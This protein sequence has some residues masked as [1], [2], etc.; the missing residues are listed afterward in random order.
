MPTLREDD[1]RPD[2]NRPSNEEIVIVEDKPGVNQNQDNDDD[3]EDD[4]RL[5]GSEDGGADDGN[6]AERSA[7]RERRRL[8]KLERKDRREQAIKRDKLELDFLR[9]RNDDLER[10]LGTVEH[11]THQADLSQID[12]QIAQAKNEA[13]MAERVIAKAVAAGNGDD[14][15]Q[16]MRYRDQAMQKANQ[17]AFAKQQAMVQRQQANQPKNEGLDDMAMHFAKE[18][19]T[20][21]SWYDPK[22]QDEDSAIVLAIDGA[23]HREGFRPDTE[24]YWDELRDRAARRIPERFKATGG[25]KDNQRQQTT[26]PR[27]QRGGPAIGSG[28]EHAPTSTRTEVYVSPERKQAL[29]DAG[30]WDDPV[31]RMKYVKRYAEYDRNNRA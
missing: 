1:E 6:D 9:K 20:E 27:Q 14:V 16:A 18:F 7:I 19:I 21:N 12:T 17:L 22:G 31:L 11:R 25:A 28:R 2:D 3:N 29:I 10:R 23:L 24:E 13:E 15:A 4:A 26:P 30:V 8:E 5:G